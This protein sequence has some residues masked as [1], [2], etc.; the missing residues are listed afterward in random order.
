MAIL[1]RIGP[2]SAFKVGLVSYALLGFVAG[3]LCSLL[4][5]TGSSLAPNVHMPF[6]PAWGLFALVLC[7]IVYGIVGG[8]AALIGAFIY[9]VAA[10]WIGG[11]QIEIR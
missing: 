1:T 6:A 11:V 10:E 4:A 3:L 8:I 7:P 2:V 9:N 5:L